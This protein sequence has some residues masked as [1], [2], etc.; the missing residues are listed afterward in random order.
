MGWIY[1]MCNQY[2][3]HGLSNASMHAIGAVIYFCVAV[4]EK[5]MSTFLTS[6]TKVALIKPVKIPLLELCGAVLLD[7]IG[8]ESNS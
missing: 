3:L 1:H 7:K 6:K 4:N 8:H 5:L 2:R